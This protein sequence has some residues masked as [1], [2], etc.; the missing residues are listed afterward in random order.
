MSMRVYLEDTDA[1]G[2]VYHASYLRFMERAR[3]EWLRASGIGLDDWQTRQRV[4][5]VVRSIAVDYLG[6]ARLD[7]R[8]DVSVNM[9]AARRASLTCEQIV[10][11]GEDRLTRA[12]VQLACIDAD[13]A[14]SGRARPVAI[15]PAIR[16][17]M[18]A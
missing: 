10:Q 5:F 17:A 18:T 6:P 15:P 11:R 3:T 4:L 9:L 14:S 7:D 16:E 2:I 8:L 13:S 1:G 12:S